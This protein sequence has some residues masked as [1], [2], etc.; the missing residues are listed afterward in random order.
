MWGLKA[1]RTFLLPIRPIELWCN[2]TDSSQVVQLEALLQSGNVCV[3]G[4]HLSFCL[5]L[6]GS[7]CM[8]NWSIFRRSLSLRRFLW[9]YWGGKRHSSYKCN[10]YSNSIPLPKGSSEQAPLPVQTAY[11]SFGMVFSVSAQCP[12]A[13]SS[14]HLPHGNMHTGF[15]H[16]TVMNTYL[17]RKKRDARSAFVC[18]QSILL[19]KSELLSPCQMLVPI[20]DL[21]WNFSFREA[22]PPDFSEKCHTEGAMNICSEIKTLLALGD[23]CRIQVSY[24][25]L[26][27]VMMVATGMTVGKCGGGGEEEPPQK[28]HHI[29]SISKRNSY[30]TQNLLVYRLSW[31]VAPVQSAT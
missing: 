13:G 17:G 25:P 3:W 29:W 6:L 28:T 11:D 12:P 8:L 16:Q 1:W 21:T 30:R 19:G 5:A 18:L 9:E 26:E 7:V 22:H 2:S 23:R 15:P 24:I 14:S 27:Q 10:L 31:Y 20:W 4:P